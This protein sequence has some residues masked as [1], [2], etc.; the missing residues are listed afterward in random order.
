MKKLLHN[1]I[2]VTPITEEKTKSGI[3]LTVEA[4]EKQLVG[5]VEK[6]GI[7][8]E[9]VEDGDTVI[10]DRLNASPIT[11]EGA[12]YTICEEDDIIAVL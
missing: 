9:N 12:E 1:Y 4:Q 2:L 11:I 10:Y 7:E 3:I 8:V 5:K 6:V